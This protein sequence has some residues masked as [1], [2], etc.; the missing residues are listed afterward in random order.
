M[1]SLPFVSRTWKQAFRAFLARS[2][3][4]KGKPLKR[5]LLTLANILLKHPV[6]DVKLELTAHVIGDATRAIRQQGV[7]IPI[8]A[9]IQVSELFLNKDLVNADEILC[10]STPQ[11]FAQYRKD[12]IKRNLD[13]A[14]SDQDAEEFVSSVLHWVQYPDCAPVAGRLLAAFIGSLRDLPTPKSSKRLFDNPIPLWITPVRQSLRAHPNLQEA[15]ENHVLPKLLQL[16]VADRQAFLRTVPLEDIG[17]GDAGK[18]TATDIQ[19]CLLAAKIDANLGSNS[20][21]REYL[22]KIGDRQGRVVQHVGSREVS[23]ANACT[24]IDAI[25][26]ATCLLDHSSPA[27]RIAALLLLIQFPTP[28][29]CFSVEVLQKLQRSIPN[30]HLEADAKT[31]NEFVASMRKLSRRLKSATTF[32]LREHQRLASSMLDINH[33]EGQQDFMTVSGQSHALK[34][35]LEGHLGFRSWYLHFLAHELRP[36]ASYQSH[37]TAL[38]VLTP[39]LDDCEAMLHSR[40]AESTVEIFHSQLLKRA[41][42]DLLLDPFDDVRQAASSILQIGHSNSDLA[43][44]V[45]SKDSTVPQTEAE[46][47]GEVSLITLDALKVAELKAEST[48]RADHADGVGRLYGILYAYCRVPRS[49][50]DWYSNANL[51]VEYIISKLEQEVAVARQDLPSAVSTASLHGHLI[52]LK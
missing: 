11:S 13:V 29:Q 17:N 31:R 19:L 27:V 32:L 50:S 22:K 28:T 30:Y 8:R 12:E 4:G 14:V 15:Y 49:F 26:L 2:E 40:S 48:G 1:H 6:V 5:L 24:G 47:L 21:N 51:I 20:D 16:S 45:N 37:I 7:S 10:C 3:N 41:L 43:T 52:A 34:Q 39:M 44:P 42:L 38:S 23:P 36:T 25:E 33:L 35:M 18:H 9:A 46:A